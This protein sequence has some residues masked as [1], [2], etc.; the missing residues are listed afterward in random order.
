[1]SV[2][3]NYVLDTSV[4]LT[5]SD[6]INKFNNHD[7]FIPLK[8]L[9]E[10]D[11]HKKRQDQVGI[12]ARQIVRTLDS[13]R[14]KG[15]LQKG[16][17]LGKGKGILRVVSFE[18]LNTSEFPADLDLSVPDHVIIATA[19]AIQAEN[20]KRKMVVVSRDINMRVICDSLGLQAEDY[21]S[22]KAVVSSEQLYQGMVVHLVDD[23]FVD[24]FYAG[25]ELYIDEDEAKSRFRAG[26]LVDGGRRRWQDSIMKLPGPAE[27]PVFIGNIF[28]GV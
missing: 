24:R 2:K 10:I 7:I 6:S 4:Y 1:M 28:D 18:S 11:K 9:E 13:I 19:L 14:E 23:Q 22:E 12:N 16:V 5:D 8:V 17:R 15:N 25:D 20:P 26:D 3:K 27:L 21:I